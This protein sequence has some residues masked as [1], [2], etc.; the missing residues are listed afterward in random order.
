MAIDLSSAYS[1]IAVTLD[2]AIPAC[3]GIYVGVGGDI[4]VNM[5]SVGTAV[6]FKNAQ[7]GSTIPVQASKVNTTGTTATNLLVLY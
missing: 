1:A 7:A 3:R 2:A 6:I 4:S 5:A